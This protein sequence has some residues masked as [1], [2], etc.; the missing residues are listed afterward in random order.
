[1]SPTHSSRQFNSE[2]KLEFSC[3]WNIHV[4]ITSFFVNFCQMSISYKYC[5]SSEIMFHINASPLFTMLPSKYTRFSIKRK[6][7]LS[8]SAIVK[9]RLLAKS[10]L[11]KSPH[12]S[13]L[14]ILDCSKQSSNFLVVIHSSSCNFL[15][16]SK[17]C[18]TE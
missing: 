8:F 2:R 10:C 13:I 12:S 9:H 11:I 16:P 3:F 7:C 14:L 5:F 6:R 15:I 18:G 4:W 17:S 1:M